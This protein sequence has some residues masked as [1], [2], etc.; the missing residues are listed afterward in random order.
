MQKLTLHL[1][2]L[3]VALNVVFTACK[4]DDTYVPR[5]NTELITYKPWRL[6]HLYFKQAIDSNWRLEDTTLLPCEIDNITTYKTNNT[7]TYDEGVVK[8][9]TSKLAPQILVSGTWSLQNNQSS[10]IVGTSS[11]LTQ[12]YT[13]EAL[14]QNLLQVS[15][16]D[17]GY[18]REVYVH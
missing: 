18:Y 16:K 12:N 11:G 14:T 15:Y 3:F 2:I 9:D 1:A 17:S 13:I 6:Q 10:L 7:F 8:C 5:T 4:K